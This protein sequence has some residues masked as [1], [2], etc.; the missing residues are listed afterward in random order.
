MAEIKPEILEKAL[1][2]LEQVKERNIDIISAYIYG[3]FARNDNNELSDID[4]AIVSNSF[5]GNILIDIEKI[6][7]ISRKVDS[8]I[9]VLPLN[10][11]SLDGFFIQSEVIEKGIRIY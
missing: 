1:E 3:S 7:G 11:E 4:L 2:Y 8:R 6:L 9:S 10:E 5:E